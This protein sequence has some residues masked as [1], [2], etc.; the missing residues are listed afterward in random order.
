MLTVVPPRLLSSPT[1]AAACCPLSPRRPDGPIESN[2]AFHYPESFCL[3]FVKGIVYISLLVD[4]AATSAM[5]DL[6]E[7][8]VAEAILMAQKAVLG[9]RTLQESVAFLIVRAARASPPPFPRNASAL[10]V[11]RRHQMRTHRGTPFPVAHCCVCFEL[12][13]QRSTLDPMF[14][15]TSARSSTCSPGRRGPSQP[16]L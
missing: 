6:D 10:L 11:A 16:S 14:L 1:P 5:Q 12:S 13:V 9:R 7:S 2:P 4:P 3:A 15:C 8:R